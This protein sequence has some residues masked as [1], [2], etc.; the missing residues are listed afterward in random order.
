MQELMV[1]NKEIVLGVSFYKKEKSFLN[2]F[3]QYETFYTAMQYLSFALIGKPYMGVG[4]NLAYKKDIFF[5]NKGFH[6]HVDL[7]GGDDDL[8][9]N[10]VATPENVQIC[11]EKDAQTL[12]IPKNTW[13]NWFRQK[14]RHLYIGKYYKSRHKWMLGLLH[15]SQMIFWGALIAYISWLFP[16]KNIQWTPEIFTVIGIFTIRLLSLLFIFKK[17]ARKLSID[18]GIFSII[19]FDFIFIM[20]FFVLGGVSFFTKKVRWS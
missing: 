1:D 11:I 13:K 6:K 14:R 3:I 12:S 17:A 2:S 15:T 8:F 10:R 19:F 20:Y 16:F 5:K 9:V 7:V 18:I 4:R